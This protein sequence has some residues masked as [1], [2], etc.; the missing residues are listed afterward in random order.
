MKKYYMTFINTKYV[1]KCRENQFYIRF[2]VSGIV[3]NLMPFD[4]VVV[5]IL[6]IS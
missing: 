5:K 4:V 6:A 2:A 1:G 3:N